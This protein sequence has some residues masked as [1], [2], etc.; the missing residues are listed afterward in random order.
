MVDFMFGNI[1]KM[2]EKPTYIWIE[3][4][5]EYNYEKLHKLITAVH[6]YI[7]ILQSKGNYS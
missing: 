2:H 1:S 6:S 4:E 5:K 7:H 3:D